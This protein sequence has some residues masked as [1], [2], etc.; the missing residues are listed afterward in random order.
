MSNL[1]VCPFCTFENEN[2]VADCAICNNIIAYRCSSCSSLNDINAIKCI[3]CNLYLDEKKNKKCKSCG[4]LNR[5]E[6][7]KCINCFLSFTCQCMECKIKRKEIKINNIIYNFIK[8]FTDYAN[9]NNISYNYEKILDILNVT[10]N[11]PIEDSKLYISIYPKIVNYIMMNTDEQKKFIKKKFK[12]KEIK[13][14]DVLTYYQKII[15]PYLREYFDYNMIDISAIEEKAIENETLNKP[16]KLK[17]VSKNIM[18]K[19]QKL[20]KYNIKHDCFCA[21]GSNIKDI[22]ILPCCEKKV[23][24]SCMIKWFKL[25]DKCPYCNKLNAKLL[26]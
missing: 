8:N 14:T 20:K 16:A 26:N 21:D 10:F 22:I 11:I 13:Y 4:Q 24:L 1:R 12:N 23:H 19:L 9:D 18:D 7:T 2:I 6:E 17:P 25:K 15:L 3:V 5:E